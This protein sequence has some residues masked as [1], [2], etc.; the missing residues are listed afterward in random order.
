MPQSGAIAGAYPQDFLKGK[1][2]IILPSDEEK[3]NGNSAFEEEEP[4]SV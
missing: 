3:K 1:S 2:D 4:G